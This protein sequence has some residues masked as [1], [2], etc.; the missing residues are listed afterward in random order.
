MMSQKKSMTFSHPGLTPLFLLPCYVKSVT[1]YDRNEYASKAQ[2]TSAPACREEVHQYSRSALPR[3]L[4][5]FPEGRLRHVLR[6]PARTGPARPRKTQWHAKHLLIR[7]RRSRSAYRSL[8]SPRLVS[9]RQ[10][11]KWT[12]LSTFSTSFLAIA[13]RG[14]LSCGAT[15]SALVVFGGFRALRCRTKASIVRLLRRLTRLQASYGT[16]NPLKPALTKRNQVNPL[17]LRIGNQSVRN[18]Q[19][20]F[21]PVAIAR[22]TA[23]F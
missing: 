6:L 18:S 16:S 8:C 10:S 12:S 23:H 17:H 1:G 2:E 20:Y 4:S 14:R 15:P 22:R 3:C 9:G 11:S 21:H 5:S 19:S 13:L 7:S